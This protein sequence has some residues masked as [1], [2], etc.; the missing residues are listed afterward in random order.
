MCTHTYFGWSDRKVGNKLQADAS[1]CAAGAEQVH[2]WQCFMLWGSI[3]G[4]EKSSTKPA[5]T[6]GMDPVLRLV[7][8]SGDPKQPQTTAASQA[9]HQARMS[10]QLKAER[11]L[12]TQTATQKSITW[13]KPN[14]QVSSSRKWLYTWQIWGEGCVQLNWELHS[15]C[16]VA[17]CFLKHQQPSSSCLYQ[18]FLSA[19]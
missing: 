8:C 15:T 18:R 13:T 6:G 5:E 4:A 2:A 10:R 1:V 7:P 19:W 16:M 12:H 11:Q 14:F 3:R 9:S 17:H